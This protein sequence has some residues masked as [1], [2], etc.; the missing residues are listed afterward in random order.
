MYPA[1][2]GD[3]DM[4]GFPHNDGGMSGKSQAWVGG[5]VSVAAVGALAGYL[6]T[7]G[8]DDADK[9][10]SVI[11]L[12]VALAGLGVAIAGLRRQARSSGGQSVQNSAI[13]SGVSQI[14]DTAGG[15]RITRRGGTPVPPRTPPPATTHPPGSD[16]GDGQSVSGTTTGGSVNQVKNTGHDVEIEE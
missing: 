1:V 4:P 8:L 15:V 14:S 12:F 2:S 10:A 11:G 16:A 9:V 5:L 6:I 13:S 3:Q 7:V